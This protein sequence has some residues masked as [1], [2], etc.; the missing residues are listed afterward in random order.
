MAP[1]SLF[2]K[3]KF[4]SN[5]VIQPSH[6]PIQVGGEGGVPQFS[7]VRGFMQGSM[8]GSLTGC[9]GTEPAHGMNPPEPARSNQNR[10]LT[11]GTISIMMI[12]CAIGR[13]VRPNTRSNVMTKSNWLRQCQSC[14]HKQSYAKPDLERDKKEKW[15][16]VACKK[17]KSEDLDFGSL[18][19]PMENQK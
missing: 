12:E 2:V 7:T 16:E 11:A 5:R 18:E 10:L 3:K 6:N 8:Q 17:C 15:R 19:R 1:L 4:L 9:A 14:G 13:Y